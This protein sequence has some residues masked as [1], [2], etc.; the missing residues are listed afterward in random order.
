V[1]R[2]RPVVVLE[3]V[4]EAQR[5]ELLACDAVRL[6]VADPAHAP[7]GYAM[8]YELEVAAVFV[9]RAAAHA[10]RDERVCGL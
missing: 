9:L 8:A 7:V 3:E 5:R 4:V 6:A 10:H 2:Y 1:Q